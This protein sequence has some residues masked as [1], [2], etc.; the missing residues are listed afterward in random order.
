MRLKKSS[1]KSMGTWAAH[2]LEGSDEVGAR[3]TLPGFGGFVGNILWMYE[4]CLS[5][6]LLEVL[7]TRVSTS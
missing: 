6:T 3:S 1:I 4:S 2:N 5:V 7:S